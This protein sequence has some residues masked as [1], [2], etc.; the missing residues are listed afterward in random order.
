MRWQTTAALAVLVIALGVFYYVYEVRLGPEREKNEGRKGRVF[1]FEP[2]DVTAARIQR[3]NE[4]IRLTREGD[5]WQLQEPVK[6][7]GDRGAVDETVT[8]VVTARMDREIAA[9][10]TDLGEFG[11]ATPAAEV[12]LT[13]GDGKTRTLDLGAKSPTGV[14]VYARE[15]DRPAVFVV[16]DSVLRDATRPVAD[17]RDKTVLAFNRADVTAVTVVLRDET[18]A[19]EHRDNRWTLTRPRTLP[20]DT[21]TVT[22]FLDKL[23]GARVKTFVT[24]SPPSLE[25]FGLERPVRIDVQTGHDKDRATKTVLLGRVDAEKKG[26]YAM[27]PGETSVLLLPEDVWA[28]VPK[29]VAALRNRVVVAYDRDKLARLDVE[30]ARGGKV[31]LARQDGHWRITAPETLPADEVEVGALLS[32]LRELRARGFVS[33]DASGIP[34]YLAQPAVTI[35]LTPEGGGAPTSVLLEPAPP[36]AAGT[37]S[38]YAAVAGQGPV[39]L[40]DAKAVDELAR[41]ARDLRDRTLL[42]G[43]EPRDV[44]RVRL[45]AG[46]TSVVLERSGEADWK[47]LEPSKGP[48]Q[49]AKVQDLLYALRGL[50][51]NDIVA[52]G[53]EDPARFGLDRPSLEVTLYKSDGGEIATVL[54]GKRDRTTAYVKTRA[55]PAIY[56]VDATRLGEPPKLPDDFKA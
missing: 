24:E 38:A 7:R 8:S 47:M 54:V 52:P 18:L 55:A 26:V 15:K 30:S 39:V 50:K 5:G 16:G 10:P 25:P 28:A 9:A 11:L 41:S 44:K 37:P 53:G 27:R 40:V 12:T 51:W 20:G 1:T 4:V 34:R 49:S 31:T 42:A 3:G 45:Q 35:T 6:A 48:A 22:D 56:A 46:G 32:R 43:V 21:D 2:K 19:V 13:L 36:A 23:Q 29:T 33:D 17:F 14:W